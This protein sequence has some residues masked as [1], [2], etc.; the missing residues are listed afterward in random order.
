MNGGSRE[1]PRRNC[2]AIAA[3]LRDRAPKHE[4]QAEAKKDFTYDIFFHF[5]FFL[6]LA[7]FDFSLLRTHFG[8]FTEV[9]RKIR[10]EVT[11]KYKKVAN[12]GLTGWQRRTAVT[13]PCF[14]FLVRSK[15][16]K[17]T[18]N[19]WTSSRPVINRQRTHIRLT[20]ES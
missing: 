18:E 4:H 10:R 12:H 2:R 17:S 13:D 20:N 8:P 9:V 1:F 3:H 5:Y 14:L 19:V 7:F 6:S 16:A 15:I 11:K